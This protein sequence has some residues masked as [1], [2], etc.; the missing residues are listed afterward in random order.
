M[1]EKV[2]IASCI[3][4][5]V[6]I[7][8]ANQL[9]LG[10]TP[11]WTTKHDVVSR[12]GGYQPAWIWTCSPSFAILHKKSELHLHHRLSTICQFIR[13]SSLRLPRWSLGEHL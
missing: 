1:V 4:S 13:I 6:L 9:I 5:R 8:I 12:V 3:L 10:G 11:L 7:A 2:L